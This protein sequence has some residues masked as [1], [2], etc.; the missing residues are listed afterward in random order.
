[1]QLLTLEHP[2]YVKAN[3]ADEFSNFQMLAQRW[4]ISVPF[5]NN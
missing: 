2:A 1:M 4:K 3:T 5:S